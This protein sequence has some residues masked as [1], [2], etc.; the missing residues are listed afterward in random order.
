MA[1]KSNLEFI[2]GEPWVPEAEEQ[3]TPET[4]PTGD[5][6]K[7]WFAPSSFWQLPESSLKMLSYKSGDQ[8]VSIDFAPMMASFSTSQ[9]LSFLGCVRSMMAVMDGKDL[10]I[11]QR[12]LGGMSREYQ[13]L[14]AVSASRGQR[15]F[16]SGTAGNDYL[17][18]TSGNDDMIGDEGDDTID[19]GAGD[20]R[21][22]GGAGNDKLYGGA[23]NDR[24]FGGAGNDYI[25]GGRG[26]DYIEGGDGDDVIV[27]VSGKNVIKGGDGND[28]ITGTGI[29]EGGRGNDKLIA[30]AADSNDTYIYN[31]G[32]GRDTIVESA[33][34][35]SVSNQDVLKFGAGIDQSQL[36]FNKQ[37]KDLNISIIG[38]DEGV[39]IKDWYRGQDKHV[40]TIQLADGKVLKD[41]QVDALVQ[42]MAA[43]APPAAGQSSLPDSYAT[44]LAPVLAANWK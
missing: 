29:M 1:A 5:L 34:K 27:D 19:G 25:D 31:R 8:G 30:G 10:E 26:D 14:L 22:F 40:E 39:V 32:D 9:Q 44:A 4:P 42:A 6:L 13:E 12:S 15:P 2:S 16:I 18:G 28:T 3:E 24:I 33:A 23:G 43:F 20:D 17:R 41:T 35:S 11:V 38:S 7:D 37:G 21:I 36:W